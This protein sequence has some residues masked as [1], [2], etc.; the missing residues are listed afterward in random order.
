MLTCEI[1][2]YSTKIKCN[3]DKHLSTKKHQNKLLKQM[4]LK[5]ANNKIKKKSKMSKNEHKMSTKEHKENTTENKFC[6]IKC[7]KTFKTKPNLRRHELHYCK[8]YKT[9]KEIIKLNSEKAQLYEQIEKMLEENGR[10]L[11][12]INHVTNNTINNDNSTVINQT[13]NIVINGFGNEDLSHLTDAVMDKLI[14]S[15]A[16]MI[17]NLTK[18][19]HFNK[20]MP[21]NM[22]MYIPSRKEKY[23]KIF[24]G[25]TWTYEAK[26]SK[27]PDIVDRN[28]LMLDSHYEDCGGNLG[29]G[30]EKS[31]NYK[32]YQKLMDGKIEEVLKNEYDQC[33]FLILNNS[34]KVTDTHDIKI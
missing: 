31:D 22:N 5:E 9:N 26:S 25:N 18:L 34:G 24:N 29:I 4:E 30:P 8:H 12:N 2:N 1:C 21:Q 10:V 23:I 3:F 28:Y 19:I 17:N 16:N 15:P 33:E 14:A 27:I 7:N 6:C 32:N 13:N 20:N 11:K